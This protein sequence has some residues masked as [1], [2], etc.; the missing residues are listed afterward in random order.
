MD[1]ISTREAAE[2]FGVTVRRVQQCCSSGLIEGAVRFGDRWM[3]PADAE[4]G[5]KQKAGRNGGPG[6]AAEKPAR[7]PMPLMSGVF[8]PGHALEYIASLDDPEMKRTAQAE[9]EYFRG[10][11]VE[12]LRLSAPLTESSDMVIRMSGL[13]LHAFSAIAVRDITAAKRDFYMGSAL[14]ENLLNTPAEK[15]MRI[16]I[17]S[18]GKV[19]LHMPIDDIDKL[20]ETINALP[21]GM[22]LFCCYL[23]AHMYYLHEEYELSLGVAGTAFHLASALGYQIESIYLGLMISMDTMRLKRPERGEL[24]FRKAW[25]RAKPDGFLQ[26]FA[27]HH[28]LVQGL[29]ESCLKKEEPEEYQRIVEIV[30]RFAD[31]WRNIHNSD[32]QDSV[33][34]DL[35]AMEFSVAMLAAKG[36]K[37]KEIADRMHISVNTVK[38][39]MKS[40]YQKLDVS[41]R[42]ELD[43]FM[44]K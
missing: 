21:Q 12:S 4:I 5:E 6:A 26:P 10:N 3:V 29:V 28:G 8:E 23:Q 18:V 40:I 35:T 2:K 38:E 7:F 43:K 44:L 11:A 24:F 13:M 20:R 9:Y 41:N 19:L 22:V 34:S 25:E 27:E 39:I 33:T 37:N 30:Y 16:F 31:G 36:W 1:Y 17:I 42:K 14:P 32:A 15:A